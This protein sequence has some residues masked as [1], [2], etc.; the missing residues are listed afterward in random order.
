[1]NLPD[2]LRD[3]AEYFDSFSAGVHP[4]RTVWIRQAA[5]EIERLQNLLNLRDNYLVA[6]DEMIPFL[7]DL[8]PNADKSTFYS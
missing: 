3:T 7:D 1:M 2:N 8:P 4:Q 6:L 5:D